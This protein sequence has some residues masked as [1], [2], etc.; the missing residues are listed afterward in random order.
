MKKNYDFSKAVKN[1]YAKRLKRQLTIRLDHETIEYFME[2]IS[3]A[4][5]NVFADDSAAHQIPTVTGDVTSG[6][7][8]TLVDDGHMDHTVRYAISQG[9]RPITAIQ[10]ATLNTATHFGL[11]RELGS[12]TPGRRADARIS[13]RRP[14]R[15]PS[16]GC[17]SG[18]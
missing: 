6:F 13:G 15:G 9:L 18:S 10:M 12:I 7:A 16:R 5:D 1:P 4:T 8:A 17:R 2:Q 11:E 3:L 14:R